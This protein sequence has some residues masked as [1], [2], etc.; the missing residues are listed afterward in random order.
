MSKR[1]FVQQIQPD[2]GGPVFGQ[3]A[4]PLDFVEAQTFAHQHTEKITKDFLMDG[5]TQALVNGFN[6]TL[7]G[8]LNV[9]IGVGHAVSIAGLSYE[10]AAASVMQLPAAH[11]TLPRIDLVYALLE[12]DAA[13]ALELRPFKRLLTSAERA[14]I[15]LPTYPDQN[16]NQPTELWNKATIAVRAGTPNATP[17]APSAGSNEVPLFQIRV[18]ALVTVLNPGNVTDVRKLIRG[19]NGAWQRI[20]TYGN[21]VTRNVGTA[22]GNV[23]EV[24]GTGKIDPAILP[25]LAIND[26][27]VVTSQAA[28][29]ALTAEVG[30]VAVRTDLSK[31]FILR[32]AP[33][34]VLANWQEL[35]APSL[36]YTPVNKAGDTMT[37]LLE[38]QNRLVIG[39][40]PAAMNQANTDTHSREVIMGLP[41]TL[42]DSNVVLS[43]HANPG[44]NGQNRIFG[45]HQV[46]GSLGTGQSKGA[47]R[48]TMNGDYGGNAH[49]VQLDVGTQLS[50]Y[51]SRLDL[52]TR[53]LT[54]V[55]NVAVTG[56]IS[57]G[58]GT[59]VI[60]HPLDPANKDLRHGFVEAPRFD[61]IYRGRLSFAGLDGSEKTVNLDTACGFSAGTFDNLIQNPQV[62]LQNL[63]N[64]VAVRV[65]SLDGADLTIE[66]EEASSEMTVE[67]LVIGERADALIKTNPMANPATG[68]LIPEVNKAVPTVDELNLLDPATRTLI[69][70]EGETINPDSQVQEEVGVLVGKQGFPRY[71]AL[72]GQTRPMRTIT[73]HEEEES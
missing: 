13:S 34:T 50:G 24:T 33:A 26:V 17:V 35:L 11:A 25:P 64:F 58:S 61:C 59:F 5:A 65:L 52:G 27:F 53:T 30:D 44:S 47:A 1:T 57:K 7:T 36:G 22:I 39:P 70:G 38:I 63:T 18:N 4:D 66:R 23:V 20:D 14:Q 69:K 62:F 54:I 67:W 16:F 40:T 41:L 42:N 46:D 60:D 19:I 73:I 9:Q 32:V 28:M 49:T 15:P 68:V 71:A 43:V 2:A 12:T 55:G 8:G 10:L 51:G 72:L 29:L 37:G 6:Y 48:I 3:I 45:V 31:S 56:S 21:V